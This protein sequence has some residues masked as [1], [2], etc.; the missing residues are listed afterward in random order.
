MN[1]TSS[2]FAVALLTA[3]VAVV[4][5]ANGQVHFI[6]AGSSAMYQG[7]GVAAYNDAQLV[8][9]RLTACNAGANVPCASKHWST[10]TANATA[11]LK[12][13][14]T[15]SVGTS[16]IPQFGNLWIDWVQDSTGAVTDLWAYLSVDSTVGVRNYL[17]M[18]RAKLIVTAPA[19]TAGAGS[20]KAALFSDNS[21]DSPITAQVLAAVGGGAG[22][23][24]T[25][26]M[27]DIRPE[28][29]LLAT[30]RILGSGAPYAVGI[31]GDT[32]PTSVAPYG[33]PTWAI[34][35]FALGYSTYDTAAQATAEGIGVPIISGEP[36]STANAIPVLFGLPG[37][38]DPLSGL[39]V[40]N[41]IQVFPVGESPILFV[42]NRFNTTTGLG[43]IIGNGGG[44][45]NK[46][47]GPGGTVQ[48]TIN[49]GQPAT[50]VSD[51]SYYVRNVWDQHPWP[52]T[53]EFPSLDQAAGGGNGCSAANIANNPGGCHVTRRPLGNLFSSGDC[54]SDSS[55]FTWPLDPTTEGLRATIPNRT[56]VPITLFLREPL[57][58]TYNTTEF[59]EIRRMGTTGGSTL[60][61]ASLTGTCERPP[62]VSQES[63]VVQPGDASLNKQCPAKFNETAANAAATEGY[64]VRGIGTGEVLNGPGPANVGDGLLNTPDSLAYAFFSFSNVSKL[65]NNL[66]YGYLMIDG[67]DGLF[68]NYQNAAQDAAGGLFAAGTIIE[69]EPV[70]SAGVP[71]T[72]NPG[73]VAVNAT[74]TT[75]GLLPACSVTALT[76]VGCRVQ[77]IWGANPSFP[78]I[79]DGSYPAW[80]ELR[81][82][83][84]PA[85]VGN[86]SIAQDAVGA[87]ALV[88]ALQ[89]DIHNG[90]N[91]SVADF[92]PFD[93]A[94]AWTANGYGDANFIRDHY[95]FVAANDTALHG[96]VAPFPNTAN[97]TTHESNVQVTYLCNG[98]VPVDGPTPVQ[99]CG[100]DAGG[101]IV[102]VGTIN[103]TAGVGGG[104]DGAI[105]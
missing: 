1:R 97:T 32:V 62:Y 10:T 65:S 56:P 34:Y 61:T 59:T 87:E 79:R 105:Q 31:P 102:P 11:Y 99:E 73:Q 68:D 37:T 85:G 41:T 93:D 18:P 81:M 45:G 52:A 49:T 25:A 95:Q 55:A 36:G 88:Q 5:V 40:S 9:A 91:F 94:L 46:D 101:L 57:S 54:E 8:P 71:L 29:A 33:A 15:N 72:H 70:G 23:T 92:L 60:C 58:G 28:D 43:Q 35:S 44:L 69:G 53:N 82:M 13:T 19:G 20:I 103:A 64:R 86:C 96:G 104:P 75:W 42:A 24:I 63:N 4:P 84:D 26:G 83:C 50:Y 22:I 48:A 74:P 30:A 80:S 17:A 47:G 100:G 21:A 3:I 38:N 89:Q 76:G 77:D 90:A 67:I 16:P 14:R 51:N 66:K 27:T 2:L 78:H 12:D 98:G 39:A 6:G 7:F